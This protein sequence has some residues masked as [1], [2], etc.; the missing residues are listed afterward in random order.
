MYDILIV[1]DDRIIL[2]GLYH[3]MQGLVGGKHIHLAQNG[4]EALELVCIK[5]IKLI[6]TD[7]K[8]PVCDGLELLEK[9]RKVDYQGEVVIISGF[10]GYD[11]VREA[12]KLGASDYLLKP[13]VPGSL[14]ATLADCDKRLRLQQA[15]EVVSAQSAGGLKSLYMQQAQLEELLQNPATAR[16]FCQDTALPDCCW[17]VFAADLFGRGQPTDLGKQAAALMFQQAVERRLPLDQHRLLQGSSSKL[18]LVCVLAPRSLL[19]QALEALARGMLETGV[20]LGSDSQLRPPQA[21]AEGCQAARV[22][23]DDLFFDLPAAATPPDAATLQQA[24]DSLS[25]CLSGCDA[26]GLTAAAD[27]LFELLGAAR[28]PFGEIRNLLSRLLYDAMNRNNRLISVVGKHKFTN[29]DLMAALQDATT[30]SW[31]KKQLITILDTYIGELGESELSTEDYM[32]QHIKRMIA[33]NYAGNLTVKE[34][35]EQLSLH[36]NYFSSLFRQKTGQT[37]CDYLRQVRIEAAVRLMDDPSLNLKVYEVGPIV[38]YQDNAHFYRAF[39]QVTGVAPGRYR[40]H[41]GSVNKG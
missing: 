29:T 5:P 4:N 8:M 39:K 28:Q 30:L 16:Q 3:M 27:L 22:S 7:I 21:L 12:M 35:S 13:V 6:F 1:D 37:F 36:P 14:K 32:M 18:W 2:Q 34:L 23:L 25:N 20:K 11:F 31:L 33:E 10:D 38:G 9:L 41:K 15:Q 26:L 19:E 24:A 17:L 40:S